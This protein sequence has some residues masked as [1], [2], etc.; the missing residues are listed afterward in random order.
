VSDGVNLVHMCSIS[1]WLEAR[2][3]GAIEPDSLTEQGFVHLSDRTQVHIP[4]NLLYLD[5]SDL[6][7][8]SIDP[9]RV[10]AEIVWEDGDPPD[11]AGTQF[12]HLYGALPAGAVVAVERYD[13]DE[14]GR[15]PQL[16]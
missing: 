13:V 3:T 15:Y 5:Q 14:S 16:H 12:P 8:L 1:D 11:A 7:L 4:A 2:S 10:G 6:V 9:L